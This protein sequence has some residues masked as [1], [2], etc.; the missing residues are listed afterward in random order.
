MKTL[1]KN[2]IE[3]MERELQVLASVEQ[4][5]IVG[6]ITYTTCGTSPSNAT[7]GDCV[8][9][10]IA[11]LSGKPYEEV[12]NDYINMYANEYYDTYSGTDTT[13][14]GWNIE[15]WKN[16]AAATIESSKST[17][18]NGV[19]A[20]KLFNDLVSSGNRES[21]GL[22]YNSSL[23]DEIYNNLSSSGSGIFADVILTPFIN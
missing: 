18:V 10:T 8:L 22:Q 17:G 4:S 23:E 5:S 19:W 20:D 14:G 16:E 6:G 3:S 9:W 12:K 2:D 11:N 1:R 7:G 15:D 13:K 21:V